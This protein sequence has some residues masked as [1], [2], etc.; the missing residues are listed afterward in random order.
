VELYFSYKVTLNKQATPCQV[1]SDASKRWEE[2]SV[3]EKA[4]AEKISFP[5]VFRSEAENKSCGKRP[6]PKRLKRHAVKQTEGI[7][8]E[9]LHRSNPFPPLSRIRPT[10]KL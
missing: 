6:E 7:Q 2:E 5:T 10:R 1:K 3:K 8:E 4:C 9:T